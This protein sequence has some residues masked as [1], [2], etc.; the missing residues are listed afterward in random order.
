MLTTSTRN[1]IQDGSY[2]DQLTR[3]IVYTEVLGWVDMGH[4]RGDDIVTLKRQFMHGE[5]SGKDYYTVTY[6]Q[7]MR[8]ARFGSAFGVGKFTHWEIKRGRSNDEINRIMLAMMMATA[9]RFESYKV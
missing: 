6:R 8:I 2:F 5:R 9:S 1:E 7:D 4:A 3:G